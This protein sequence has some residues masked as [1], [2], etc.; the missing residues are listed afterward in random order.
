MSRFNT[1]EE[2]YLHQISLE[3]NASQGTDIYYDAQVF[4]S[5]NIFLYFPN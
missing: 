4:F 3:S 1:K 5:K 2:R